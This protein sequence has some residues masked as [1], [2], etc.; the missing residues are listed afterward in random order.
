MLNEKESFFLK[1]DKNADGG[2]WLWTASRNTTGTGQFWTNGKLVQSHRWSYIQHHGPIPDDKII[3]QTC[4]QILCV[5]PDHLVLGIPHG[6]ITH[7]PRGHHYNEKNTRIY[8]G[9]RFCRICHRERE[10]RQKTNQKNTAA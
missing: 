9:Q 10:R 2:C 8:R 4:K 1:V 5:N 6:Q 7:C 3:R